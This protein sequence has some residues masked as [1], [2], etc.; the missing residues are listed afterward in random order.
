MDEIDQKRGID[1]TVGKEHLTILSESPSF[2]VLLKKAPKG[3]RLT[4]EE[5]C[6]T[7]ALVRKASPQFYLF[8]K[9]RRHLLNDTE[10][11]TCILFHFSF[12]TKEVAGLLG[13]SSPNISQISGRI[14]KKLFDDK[15]SGR[16]LKERMEMFV[17]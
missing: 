11:Y 6:M 7:D 17:Q 4:D 12:T 15:G 14:M 1:R 5:K 2:A 16:N 8:L 9:Q 3:E 10:Y 13:V